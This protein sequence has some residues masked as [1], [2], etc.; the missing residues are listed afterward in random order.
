MKVSRLLIL[1]GYISGKD[2]IRLA[3]VDK[4]YRR[5]IKKYDA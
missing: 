4:K 3:G 5:L 1:G 2:Q